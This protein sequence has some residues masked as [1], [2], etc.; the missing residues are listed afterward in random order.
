MLPKITAPTSLVRTY[1][2]KSSA[3]RGPADDRVR[4]HGWTMGRQRGNADRARSDNRLVHAIAELM[5]VV[6]DLCRFA[7]AFRLLGRIAWAETMTEQCA[8]H[9]ARR[10]PSRRHHAPDPRRDKNR[11]GR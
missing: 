7:A 10:L 8:D 6:R 9:G 4:G 5:D 11:F 2:R 1:S 3:K